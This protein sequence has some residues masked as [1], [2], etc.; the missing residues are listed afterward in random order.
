MEK[1]EGGWSWLAWHF[2][3]ADNLKCGEVSRHYR[4]RKATAARRPANSQLR[5]GRSTL[6]QILVADNIHYSVLCT[7]PYYWVLPTSTF[8]LLRI[9]VFLLKPI[10]LH[11]ITQMATLLKPLLE[12]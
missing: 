7:T 12:Q 5:Y 11:H 10:V 1:V 2:N 6:P 3:I 9:V 8:T 4:G